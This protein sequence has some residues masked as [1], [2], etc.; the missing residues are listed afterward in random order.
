MDSAVNSTAVFYKSDSD[1]HTERASYL[2]ILTIHT[3]SKGVSL[4]PTEGKKTQTA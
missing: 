4:K 3:N 2:I 1:H